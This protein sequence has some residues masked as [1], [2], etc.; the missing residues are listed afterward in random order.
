QNI[1]RQR[2]IVEQQSGPFG[3]DASLWNGR[4]ALD[5]AGDG[6]KAFGDKKI[7]SSD[8]AARPGL[9]KLQL[10]PL[11]AGSGKA[12]GRRK[13]SAEEA[14]APKRLESQPESRPEQKFMDQREE[15][16]KDKPDDKRE[17]R[18]ED[19][20][21]KNSVCSL[22]SCQSPSFC[23]AVG[24][25]EALAESADK[26]REDGQSLSSAA[27]GRSAAAKAVSKTSETASSCGSRG[28]RDNPRPTRRSENPG[29]LGRKANAFSVADGAGGSPKNGPINAPKN[30][31]MIEPVVELTG[32]DLRLP[33]PGL[34]NATNAAAAVAAFL[35]V[36]GDARTAVEVLSELRGVRRRQQVLLDHNGITLIDDFAHH[37]TAVD[38]TLS[39]LRSGFPGR[40][41]LAAFEPRSNTSRRALFQEAYAKSLRQ[42]NLVFLSAVDKPDKAPEGDRLDVEKLALETGQASVHD[43]PA[44]LAS[45]IMAEVKSGDLIVL[46]SNGGFGGLARLLREEL[47]AFLDE[48]SF[49]DSWLCGCSRRQ[50]PSSAVWTV[51]TGGPTG[52]AGGYKF[53]NVALLESALTHRSIIGSIRCGKDAC[54]S[55][56]S[57]CV[58]SSAGG[59]AV[60]AADAE[61]DNQRLEF[62]GD[63]VLNLAIAELLFRHQPRRN[64]GD[65]TRQRASLVCESRLAEVARALD[66]GFRVVM[67][68]G[69]ESSG[70]RERPSV[71]AD[72]ME[73]VL[74]A[75][76]LDGGHQEALKMIERL[77]GSYL[78]GSFPKI[79]DHKS[80]LQELSQKL[81][82]GQ[83]V[84]AM[85]D[86]SGPS[87]NQTFTMSV[88]IDGLKT[89][90]SG[91]T[92][93]MAG[94]RAARQLF[95]ALE[96]KYPDSA[97]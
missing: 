45:A 56:K 31:H 11:E 90:A 80:R 71:L 30:D 55:G 91:A 3:Q 32:L 54:D 94:Q 34:Y 97:E 69:E 59:E 33:K 92:K 77:W 4:E 43:S 50:E 53:K 24:L 37:P 13:K 64:E 86:V 93:K 78:D 10:S 35:A 1:S 5:S 88:E 15:K 96:E 84:Y 38:K 21:V 79:I 51:R 60:S 6:T 27:S 36:G 49:A 28:R 68:P 26:N 67:S 72:A 87:H 82:L 62:L 14:G 44:D 9:K 95:Q 58:G 76:Y 57:I 66:L 73:A 40:R 8:S 74:G 29:Q 75:V 19:K 63:S 23:Q 70:G 7:S 16:R 17:D 85:A 25:E 83:P 20:R 2:P 12:R 48:G 47:E 89:S 18:R 61:R 41:I 39:A 81:K 65:M 52:E 42:A 46:M 22:V